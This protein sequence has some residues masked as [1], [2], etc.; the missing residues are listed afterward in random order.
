MKRCF[1]C[2]ILFINKAL[3]ARKHSPS[4]SEVLRLFPP[5]LLDEVHCL[6]SMSPV[7]VTSSLLFPCELL[8]AGHCHGQFV[9][10]FPYKNQVCVLCV[11]LICVGVGVGVCV[12]QWKEGEREER[13]FIRILELSAK[14]HGK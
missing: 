9:K 2:Q 7:L 3:I 14:G 5:S 6:I 8:A 13:R 4:R 1:S 12:W 11:I 10:A